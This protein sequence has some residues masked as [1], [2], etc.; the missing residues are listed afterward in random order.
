M[1]VGLKRF[2]VSTEQVHVPVSILVLM[3]VG[4]KQDIITSFSVC[5]LVGF[6]PCFNGCRSE[7]C[8]EGTR[9]N[10]DTGFQSLF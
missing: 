9:F 6:N 1:D 7:A 2:L 5:V 10:A 3:D 8:P 4:L